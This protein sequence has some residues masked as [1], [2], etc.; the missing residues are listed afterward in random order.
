MIYICLLPAK[1]VDNSFE[2]SYNSTYNLQET[3]IIY[4]QI[5]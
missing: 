4:I 5:N 1:N 2:I 3:A